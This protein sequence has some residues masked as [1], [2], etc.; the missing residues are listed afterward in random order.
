[1]KRQVHYFKLNAFD[2]FETYQVLQLGWMDA[3]LGRRYLIYLDSTRLI[4][5][6]RKHASF[7]QLVVQE[8]SKPSTPTYTLGQLQG[9]VEISKDSRLI[10]FLPV[11]L[12]EGAR[13]KK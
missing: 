4:S 7:Y 2:K 3:W 6:A 12:R 5:L 9:K 8:L 13:P 10:S 1:M 11:Q